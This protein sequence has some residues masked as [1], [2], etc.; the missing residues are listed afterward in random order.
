TDAGQHEGVAVGLGVSHAL[1]A[2]HAAGAADVFYDDLLAQNLAHALPHDPTD[3][4]LWAT[5]CE[6]NDHGHRAAR[7]ILRRSLKRRRKQRANSDRESPVTHGWFPP[8]DGGN[9]LRV[10]GQGS[11]SWIDAASASPLW[12]GQGARKRHKFRSLPHVSHRHPHHPR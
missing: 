6:R 11:R 5:R 8:W 1:G 10:L 9:T 2:G 4:V 12:V 7:K 3:L